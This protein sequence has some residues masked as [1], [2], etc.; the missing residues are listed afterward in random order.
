MKRF[1]STLLILFSFSFIFAQSYSPA[2]FHIA[3][4]TLLEKSKIDITGPWDFYWGFF[5]SPYDNT[6]VPNCQVTIP[7]KWNTYDL[8]P[9]A[10]KIAATGKGAGTYK[11]KITGLKKNTKYS[12]L[13][14][15]LASTAFKV[16]LDGTQ[17]YSSG[18]PTANFKK[19]KA[20]QHMNLVT[21]TSDENGEAKLTIYVSNKDYRKG[22]LWK[23]V[24]IQEDT[25]A[26]ASFNK[27]IA[28]QSLLAGILIAVVF[29]CLFISILNRDKGSMFLGIFTFL[30][31][32]RLC[33]AD[34]SIIKYFLP[35]IPYSVM[36]R[37]EYT[38]LIFG[39]PVY[40]F[41]LNAL[42][43]NLFKIIKPK[44]I[45][46]PSIVFAVLVY[47]T[48]LSFANKMVPVSEIYVL[49]CIVI[50]IFALF[51]QAIKYDDFVSIC[52][53]SSLLI[54]ALGFVN[55]L[56]LINFVRFKLF[57]G[58]KIISWCFVAYTIFQA[59]ILAYLENQKQTKLEQKN[60]HYRVTN[61]AYN[62]FI[63]T[64]ALKL[65]SDKEIVD[66]SSEEK[67]IKNMMI[68]SA[69]IENLNIDELS[70]DQIFKTLTKY[71]EEI[72]PIIRNAGGTIIK[73]TGEKILAVFPEN[74]EKALLC[75]LNMQEKMKELRFKFREIQY[76]AIWIGIGIHYGTVAIGTTGT[77][78][79]ISEFEMSRDIDIANTVEALT[80]SM[81]KQILV[82]KE[83]IA[84]AAKNYKTAGKKFEF[85]G[86]QV[87]TEANKELYALFSETVP[88]GM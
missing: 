71:T 13:G 8:P 4:N 36:L 79:T 37:F 69:S 20:E 17:I 57:N 62:R 12:F 9:E 74:P 67:N 82:T 30:L 1:L 81:K 7:Q 28:T 19:T 41:Y 5:I 10:A 60:S 54:I 45:L 88:E 22:G 65:V 26:R 53:L 14:Y 38:V 77:E 21:F 85:H 63:P 86:N 34:F 44:Y 55:D 23:N 42:N 6:T 76:P 31:L 40:M 43:P 51:F 80:K 3:D 87:T 47:F 35:F 61:V 72:N 64:E 33:S 2:E 29:Y 39:P 16:L 70:D 27:R 49:I 73:N 24:S 68:L 83:G 84:I 11:I 50:S 18:K 66:I 15:D 46:L 48:P 59:V 58:N 78:S 32:L 52:T 56:L 25:S 75:A